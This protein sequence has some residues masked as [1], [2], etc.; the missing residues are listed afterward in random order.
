MALV[1]LAAILPSYLLLATAFGGADLRFLRVLRFFRLFRV[2]KLGRYSPAVHTLTAVFHERRADLAVAMGAVGILLVLSSSAVYLA[3]HE[4]Q[5]DKFASI[6]DSM[7][8]AIVTLTTIGYGDVVPITQ[9]GKAFAGVTAILGVGFIALP[10]AIL[11]AGFQE[12]LHRR[13]NRVVTHCPNCGEPLTRL[14]QHHAPA[15]P[16]SATV[17][18]EVDGPAQ[19][20]PQT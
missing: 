14:L 16:D 10:T 3:E 1:D 13:K 6:P 12:H 9:L 5:P 19:P 17:T 8:W 15:A 2:L 7:W 4:A 18:L 11:A 20:P